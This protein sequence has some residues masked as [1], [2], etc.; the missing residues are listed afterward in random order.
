MARK[1]TKKGKV[2]Q[3]S[4]NTQDHARLNL[5]PQ[6]RAVWKFCNVVALL[7]AEGEYYDLL[8]P[9]AQDIVTAA[10]ILAGKLQGQ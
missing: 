3:H 2:H 7:S 1:L 9:A 4:L 8:P 6:Q 5:T 10:K